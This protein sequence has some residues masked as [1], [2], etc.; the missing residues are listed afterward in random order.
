MAQTTTSV[1]N[2]NTGDS[3]TAAE[4]NNVTAAVNANSAD[5]Q[6]RLTSLEADV[7]TNNAKNTYPSGDSTKLSGIEAGATADQTGSEIKALYE[8]EANTNAYTDAE[9][10]KL[11]G[12][13]SNATADQTGVE[14]KAAY[15]GEANTNAFTD[16]EKAKL[17]SLDSS[18]FLGTF[19]STGALTA[20]HPSPVEGSYAFID[21][22][23]G[24]D[25][26]VYI[27]DTDSTVYVEQ[28]SANIAET[29]ASVKT[30]Y[31]SNPDTNAF[32]DAEQAKLG[33]I[34]V[35]ADVTDAA[36]VT[37]AGA[38]MDSELT[39]EAAVKAL[40]QGVSTTDSPSFTKLDVTGDGVNFSGTFL[41]TSGG[42]GV[43]INTADGTANNGLIVRQ[44]SD[45]IMNV[46][47]DGL[48]NGSVQFSAAGTPTIQLSAS[49]DS[50]FNGGNLGISQSTPQSPIHLTGAGIAGNGV[51]FE[52][53][54]TTNEW[55]IG[56]S[57]APDGFVL[58]DETNSAVRL[59]VDTAGNLGLGQ[60]APEGKLHV[61]TDGTTNTIIESTGIGVND[62]AQLTVK[63]DAGLGAVWKNPTANTGYG[64][65]GS[66][67]VGTFGSDE[68]SL[69]TNNLSRVTI[70]T[71]GNVGVGRTDPNAKLDVTGEIRAYPTVGDAT[72]RLGIND[73]E[74]GKVAATDGGDLYFEASGQEVLRLLANGNMLL[75]GGNLAAVGPDNANSSII[76][77]TT[78][79]VSTNMR[80]FV[81]SNIGFVGTTGVGD[82]GIQVEGAVHSRFRSSGTVN[83]A[84]LPQYADDA[85]AGVGGLVAGDIY[86]TAAGDLKVKL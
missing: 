29:A 37:A 19:I 85:A 17:A 36:N 83:I 41:N 56:A 54:F 38:L 65:A 79:D 45:N 8:A 61:E 42:D 76:Q 1:G 52:N 48:N 3:L 50:F 24:S 12:I 59:T 6:S 78:A 21:T 10:T 2:K 86:A 74:K 84:S 32:T 77:A 22:G 31:E 51:R 20:A 26:V 44:G 30:K 43:L 81:G 5:A 49:G 27:W 33:G 28:A 13:E 47:S 71:G 62:F 55:V 18:L 58:W 15:E 23:A 70:G 46:Y 16:A 82:V 40:D 57:S 73:A 25:A 68:L 63:S 9:K 80:M 66:M 4:F 35:A 69:V 11:G 53:D 34:E 67:N 72:L 60:T 64:G 14:I 75:S 39:S 7:A